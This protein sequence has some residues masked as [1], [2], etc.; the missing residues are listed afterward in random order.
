MAG[1][2]PDDTGQQITDDVVEGELAA[3]HGTEHEGRDDRL[4]HAARS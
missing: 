2:G 4:G 1:V 3:I